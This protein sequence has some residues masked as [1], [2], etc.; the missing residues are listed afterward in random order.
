M[1]RYI[2]RGHVCVGTYGGAMYVLVYMEGPCM[3]RCIW[4]GHVC[5]GTYGGAMYV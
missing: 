3:C 4:R 1:C 5:V 2:W